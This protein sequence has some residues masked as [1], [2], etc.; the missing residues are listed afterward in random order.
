MRWNL[1]NS[2][3]ALASVGG[4]GLAAA[5]VVVPSS[6]HDDWF[7]RA[8]VALVFV[9]VAIFLSCL[10][11]DAVTWLAGQRGLLQVV[12]GAGDAFHKIEFWDEDH[13]P[14]EIR[15]QAAERLPTVSFN[16]LLT[17]RNKSSTRAIPRCRARIQSVRPPVGYVQLPMELDWITETGDVTEVDLEPGGRGSLLLQR[18]WRINTVPKASGL[19]TPT[20]ARLTTGPLAAFAEEQFVITIVVW[21]DETS[22]RRGV[23]IRKMQDFDANYVQV[24][25]S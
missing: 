22:V 2:G 4:A 1:R 12:A 24:E 11:I 9:G 7:V 10:A 16:T 21:S 8:F 19:T 13:V 3:L 6:Q 5:V 14:A 20:P 23:S 18:V 17:V 25:V 15:S